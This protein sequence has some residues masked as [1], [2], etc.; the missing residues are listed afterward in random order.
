MWRALGVIV[1]TLLLTGWGGCQSMP[2]KVEIVT[3]TVKEFV[4]VPDELTAPCDIQKKQA[5]TYGE[6]KRLR[7][8]DLAALRECSSRME[9][10]RSIGNRSPD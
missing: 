9:K 6:L 10:I 5:N 2:A 4:S 1:F 3:V 7:G 8:V